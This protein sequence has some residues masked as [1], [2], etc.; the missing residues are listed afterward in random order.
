MLL[1]NEKHVAAHGAVTGIVLSQID[2]WFTKASG[3]NSRYIVQKDGH[4]WLARSHAQLA[5]ETGLSERNVRFA[6]GE[7]R[8][9]RLIVVGRTTFDRAMCGTIR[10]VQPPVSVGTCDSECRNQ[11][12][13]NVASI[14]EET[15]VEIEENVGGAAPA[16]TSE[17]SP[18]PISGSV[19]DVLAGRMMQKQKVID[20]MTAT[21]PHDLA[22]IFRRAWS[23]TFP[24]HF[25]PAFHAKHF[26]QL[27]QIA[28][29]CPKGVPVGHLIK[30]AVD[31]WV[32]F[33]SVAVAEQG[34]I[35]P[36]LLPDLN[37]MKVF[38]QSL[39]NAWKS[40]N[41]SQPVTQPFKKPLKMPSAAHMKKLIEAEPED[42][43]V[44]AGVLHPE[45]PKMATEDELQ[46][47]LGL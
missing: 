41:A 34:A 43:C 38:T 1:L 25:L 8:K 23:E 4:K 44:E 39:V 26:G 13:V 30:F 14:E 16:P 10:R 45:A 27:K 22:E 29:A 15:V 12:T 37:F 19:K 21:G 47:F 40:V 32:H 33:T 18:M 42:A 9:K 36:P 28:A 17:E 3:G 35:K 24:D 5:E 6:L 11:P 46:K 2:Y 7:L 31:Q 20:P